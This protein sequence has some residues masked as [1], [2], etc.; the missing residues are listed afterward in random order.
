MLSAPIR[1]D[2]IALWSL[3]IPD[4]EVR[5]VPAHGSE[6]HQPGRGPL[7]L[8][9]MPPEPHRDRK[10]QRTGERSRKSPVATPPGRGRRG[11][12]R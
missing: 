6:Q 1:T 11:F 7:G 3:S 4:G 8:A 2:S 5:Y 9:G 12:R 10:E